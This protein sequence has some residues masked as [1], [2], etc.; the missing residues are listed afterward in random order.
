M[1]PEFPEHRCMGYE[2]PIWLKA[3]S[4]CNVPIFLDSPVLQFEDDFRG[5]CQSGQRGEVMLPASSEGLEE[6]YKNQPSPFII[7]HHQD[8]FRIVRSW[9]CVIPTISVN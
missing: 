7:F 9:F 3:L 8:H 2:Y 5:L 4:K 1:L 6:L